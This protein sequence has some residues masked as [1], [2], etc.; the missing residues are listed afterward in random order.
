MT[1]STRGSLSI[2]LFP[3]TDPLSKK[4]SRKLCS[5][6]LTAPLSFPKKKRKKKSHSLILVQVFFKFCQMGIFDKEDSDMKSKLVLEIC[7]ISTTAIGC[8]HRRISPP[9][10]AESHFIDW[11]RLLGVSF[12]SFLDLYV[13]QSSSGYLSFI[14][15]FKFLHWFQ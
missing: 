12:S 10:P 3:P 6:F 13:D 11:Y 15:D 2:L 4:L 1:K 5:F 7:S 8:A 14:Q 9:S